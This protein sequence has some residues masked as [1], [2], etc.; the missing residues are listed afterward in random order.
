MIS[1]FEYHLLEK[2]ENFYLA[3]EILECFKNRIAPSSSLLQRLYGVYKADTINKQISDYFAEHSIP[4][5]KKPRIHDS[6]APIEITNARKSLE[7]D[8]NYL[9]IQYYLLKNKIPELLDLSLLYGQYSEYIRE[10]YGKFNELGLKRKCGLPA[11]SHLNRVGGVSVKLNFNLPGYYEYGAIAAIHDTIE[12][13]FPIILDGKAQRYNFNRYKEFIDIFIPENLQ[14]PI[15]IL[16]NHYNMLISNIVREFKDNDLV[17]NKKNVIE[18]LKSLMDREYDEL[19]TY[20]RQ[21]YTILVDED[22]DNKKDIIEYIR[23]KCY[24]E[25][26]LQGITESSIATRDFRLFE[27][28]GVDLSDNAHGKDALSLGGRIRNINKSVSWANYGYGMHTTWQPL[29]NHI[30]ECMEDSFLSSEVIILRDLLQPQS[31]MDFIMSSLIIFSKLE[32]VFYISENIR[33]QN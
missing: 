27:I 23:W 12:D 19:D 1:R 3:S 7:E 21:M 17:V 5:G 29:N 4:E 13:L 16:T 22:L 18:H 32:N 15:K 14:H 20:I 25:L 6:S 24:I 8:K 28:K 31:S 33:E 26:Y 9:N 2:A 11:S 10:I 30:Q